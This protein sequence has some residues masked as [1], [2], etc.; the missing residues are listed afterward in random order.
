MYVVVS[1][2]TSRDGLKIVIT[3]SDVKVDGCAKNVV[4]VETWF[5]TL[6]CTA[7]GIVHCVCYVCAFVL[8]LFIWRFSFV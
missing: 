7:V 8:I 3:D 1:R 6:L 2:I 4:Y 5:E